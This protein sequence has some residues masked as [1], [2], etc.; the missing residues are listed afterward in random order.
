VKKLLN[1]DKPKK[2]PD[3]ASQTSNAVFPEASQPKVK[4]LEHTGVDQ[5]NANFV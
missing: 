3:G 2:T 4:D 5:A 1:K